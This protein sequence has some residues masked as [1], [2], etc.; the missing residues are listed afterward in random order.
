MAH[1]RGN[2]G[3]GKRIGKCSEVLNG[4]GN[5]AVVLLNVARNHFDV[6]QN[7][8]NARLLLDNYVVDVSGGAFQIADRSRNALQTL[9]EVLFHIFVDQGLNDGYERVN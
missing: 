9:V 5:I 6:V 7:G 3:F 8:C 2:V 4:A 1:S